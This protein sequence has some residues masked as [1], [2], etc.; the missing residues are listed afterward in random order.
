MPHT[1]R[2]NHTLTVT[3]N[4]PVAVLLVEQLIHAAELREVGR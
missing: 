2:S 3:G 4:I 1:A